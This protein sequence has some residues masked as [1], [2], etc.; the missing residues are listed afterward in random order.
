V[1][2]GD[3]NGDGFADLIV[4]APKSDSGAFDGGASYVVFGKS[5]GFAANLDASSLDGTNGFQITNDL[6]ILNGGTL[7]VER[8]T[9]MAMAL[10][11]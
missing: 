4:N 3:V 11:T 5:D 7:L 2:Q 10:M 9:S 6:P 8:A 1:E